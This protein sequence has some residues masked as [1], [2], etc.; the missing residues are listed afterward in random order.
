MKL[1]LGAYYP[2]RTIEEYLDAR[3]RSAGLSFD[4]L[5][6]RGIIRGAPQ[7]VYY[8]DGVAPEFLTPS[9]RSSSTRCS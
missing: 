7:P 8:E 1:G 5:K 3:L 9:G 2:W 6:A 4:T